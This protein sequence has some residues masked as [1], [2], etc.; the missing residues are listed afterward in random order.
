MLLLLCC[1][2]V[3]TPAPFRLSQT[4]LGNTGMGKSHQRLKK[5]KNICI[6]F[7]AFVSETSSF[8]FIRSSL[9]KSP[10][11]LHYSCMEQQHAVHAQNLG[12]LLVQKLHSLNQPKAGREH[13][14]S[15]QSSV[16]LPGICLQQRL[17]QMIFKRKAKATETW[18][19]NGG[20]WY[21]ECSNPG[22]PRSVL[23]PNY[24][25]ILITALHIVDGYILL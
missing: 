15:D 12:E 10:S 9:A 16:Y 19:S 11:A 17:C 20:S 5:V 4:L 25:L 3:L 6:F 14:L 13:A 7:A 24:L 18:Q 2:W 21:Q 22:T 8:I 23:S 1:S